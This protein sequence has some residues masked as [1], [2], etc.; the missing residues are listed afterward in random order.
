MKEAVYN[1]MK[2]GVLGVAM[3]IPGVSGGTM[4]LVMGIYERLL[5][6]INRITPAALKEFLPPFPEGPIAKWRAACIRLDAIFLVLLG[7]GAIIIFGA[8]TKV[9]PYMMQSHQ[10]PTFGFFLGLILASVIIP[11]KLVKKT[12]WA[13]ILAI[14]IGTAVT[15]YLGHRDNQRQHERIVSYQAMKNE[16]AKKIIDELERN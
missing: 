1:L 10:E 11:F 6:A 8:L 9:M 12:T 5:M 2:G 7:L 3:I 15:G 14:V 16:N 13:V 4:A